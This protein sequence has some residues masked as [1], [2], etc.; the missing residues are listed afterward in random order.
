MVVAVTIRGLN[1]LNITLRKVRKLPQKIIAFNH[2]FAGDVKKSLQ[3]EFIMGTVKA[4]RTRTAN[5]FAVRKESKVRS[6]VTVPRSA[7]MLDSME[8]HYV[9]L[10]RGR[11]ITQWVRKYYTGKPATSSRSRVWRG[12][13]GGILY[14]EGKKSNLFVTPHPF[15]QKG[16]DR[17]M[18]TYQQRL[19]RAVAKAVGG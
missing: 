12:P 17:V 4:P 1:R 2:R 9:P 16:L 14:V 3:R 5:R 7:A 8:P 6:V 19:T 18:R 11:K 15:I 10:K 13:L